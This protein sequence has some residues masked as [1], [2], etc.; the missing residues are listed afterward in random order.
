MRG[1]INVFN[2]NYLLFRMSFYVSV[3]QC[4]YV[5]QNISSMAKDCYL[6]ISNLSKV[7]GGGGFSH[8][9]YLV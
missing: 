5:L 6:K 2:K 8:M 3:I 1:P 9:E 4:M 7:S